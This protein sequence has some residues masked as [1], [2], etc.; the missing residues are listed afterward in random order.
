MR[1]ITWDNGFIDTDAQADYRKLFE[2][3]AE[4]WWYL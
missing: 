4:D 2:D 3:S 1:I